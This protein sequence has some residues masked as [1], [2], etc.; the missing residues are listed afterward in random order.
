MSSYEPLISSRARKDILKLSQRH[1]DR[2]SEVL[3]ALGKNPFLG[4]KLKGEL[5]GKYSYRVWPYRI[6]YTIYEKRV[7][8]ILRGQHR[9][10]AYLRHG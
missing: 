8:Y 10:S 7:V 1:K 6:I 9:Q 2:L 3:T 5:E 4:K